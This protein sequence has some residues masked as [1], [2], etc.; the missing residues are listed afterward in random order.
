MSQQK[1]GEEGN[2]KHEPRTKH[3]IDDHFGKGTKTRNWKKNVDESLS[4]DES[5]ENLGTDEDTDVVPPGSP[6]RTPI[7]DPETDENKVRDPLRP[8]QKNPRLKSH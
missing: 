3:Y 8:D 5:E 6:E 2:W 7:E 1:F 4:A